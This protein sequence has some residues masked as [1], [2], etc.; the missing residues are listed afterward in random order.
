MLFVTL[1][2]ARG[3]RPYLDVYRRTGRVSRF[4][5]TPPQGT[6][7]THSAAAPPP[8]PQSTSAPGAPSP[9]TQLPQPPEATASQV[10]NRQ[11]VAWMFQFLRPVK[12]LVL[13]ACLY[14]SLWVLAEVLTVRQAGEV[15]NHIRSIH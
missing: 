8:K 12:G 10:T 3:V 9:R 1:Q 5:R 4:S 15:A 6:V 7:T 2:L 14:L 13:M 11:L